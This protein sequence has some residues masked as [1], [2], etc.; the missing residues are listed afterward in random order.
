MDRADNAGNRQG[1]PPDAERALAIARAV[2][3]RDPADA[4]ARR[5]LAVSLDAFG[6]L[7]KSRGDLDGALAAYREGLTLR[8]ELAA[9]EPGNAQRQREA[10][11]IAEKMAGVLVMKGALASHGAGASERDAS[12]SLGAAGDVLAARGDP[13]NALAAWREGIRRRRARAAEQPDNPALLHDMAWRLGTVGDVLAAQGDSEGALAAYRE[14]VEL[15]RA[16]AAGEPGNAEWRRDLAWSLG[17]L[18]RVLAAQGDAPGALAAYRE[19]LAVRRELA[20]ADAA[21]RQAQRDVAWSLAAIG[22]V[23]ET[24]GDAAGALAHYHECLDFLR[25]ASAAEPDNGEVRQQMAAVQEKIGRLRGMRPQQSP[26]S[27]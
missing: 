26:P 15:R 4:G 1:A 3:A 11:R 18:G 14:A 13:A 22:G 16:L 10:A 2:L 12:W 21:N 7:L 23:L 8:R 27:P 5:T 9:A 20:A 24:Q 17:A 6:D 19:G 25:A